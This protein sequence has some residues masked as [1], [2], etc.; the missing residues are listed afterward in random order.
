[1]KNMKCSRCGCP[2]FYGRADGFL[3][4][5]ENHCKCSGC[6]LCPECDAIHTRGGTLSKEWEEWGAE[7]VEDESRGS[8]D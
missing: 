7:E 8:P 3:F 1:M 5:P 2:F 6:G 4:I